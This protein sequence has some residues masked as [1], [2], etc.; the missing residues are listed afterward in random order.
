MVTCME[1]VNGTLEFLTSLACKSQPH[2][3]EQ[4]LLLNATPLEVVGQE[5]LKGAMM[6]LEVE[7]KQL[8]SLVS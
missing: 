5:V 2:L 7:S 6:L 3:H 1:E 4:A 8:I